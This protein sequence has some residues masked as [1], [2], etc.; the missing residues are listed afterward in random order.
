MYTQKL[1]NASHP[2]LSAQKLK[3]NWKMLHNSIIS[4]TNEE[5]DL[6]KLTGKNY[7]VCGFINV[8]EF[9]VWV[10]SPHMLLTW[11]GLVSTLSTN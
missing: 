10:G 11:A 2:P 3:V 8:L 6:E 1:G 9:N 5:V 7:G 4:F